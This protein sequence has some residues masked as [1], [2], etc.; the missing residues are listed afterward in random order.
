MPAFSQIPFSGKGCSLKAIEVSTGGEFGKLFEA[1]TSYV[2]S[3]H[4]GI[5]LF[6]EKRAAKMVY[7]FLRTHLLIIARRSGAFRLERATTPGSYMV[8]TPK[9]EADHDFMLAEHETIVRVRSLFVLLEPLNLTE[10]MG[11][12]LFSILERAI[13]DP[14]TLAYVNEAFTMRDHQ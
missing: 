10:Q 4:G 3:L 7:S 6:F 14:F 13:Q 2:M 9:T 5:V 1:G 12:S 8:V 11:C